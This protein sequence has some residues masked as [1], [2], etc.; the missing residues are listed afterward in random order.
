MRFS[1]SKRL[2]TLEASVNG[3]ELERGNEFKYSE[4]TVYANGRMKGESI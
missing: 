4:L 1:T 3:V 2:G